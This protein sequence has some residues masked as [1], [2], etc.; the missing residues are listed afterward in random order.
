MYRTWTGGVRSSAHAGLHLLDLVLDD[1]YEALTVHTA[2]EIADHCVI[3]LSLAIPPLQ[4]TFDVS[5][6]G[7]R[8]GELA[9]PPPQLGYHRVGV[10]CRYASG[11]CY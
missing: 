3:L 2:P 8:R 9:R 7:V 10:A 6:L 5:R 4:M 1:L 11:R